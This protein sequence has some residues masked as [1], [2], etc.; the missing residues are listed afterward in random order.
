M[1]SDNDCEDLKN[2][3]QKRKLEPE[4][5][6]QNQVTSIEVLDIKSKLGASDITQI[7]SD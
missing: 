3:T 4:L 5:T 6:T 7:V 1:D 2:T